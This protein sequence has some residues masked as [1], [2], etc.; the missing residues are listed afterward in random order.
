MPRR[1]VP[2][3]LRI[4]RCRPAL[5]IIFALIGFNSAQ[6]AADLP[7][8]SLDFFE[9]KI[10]PVLSERCYSCH[11]ARSEKLKGGLRLDSRAGV[12]KG[13][14]T[15]PVLTPG[16]PDKSRL[17][18]AIKYEN[19][20]L[21]MPPKGKLSEE[22]I[23]DLSNWVKLGAPWPQETGPALASPKENFDLAQRRQ[24]HWAWQPIRRAP[25]PV[26]RDQAWP[27]SPIDHFIL[28]K[29]EANGL[30][31]AP[32]ADQRT[33]VRRM[34]FDL[35]G[36][37]PTPDEAE[38]FVQ[39]SSSGALD[40]LTGRLLNSPQFGERWARH[41]LDL[42]RYSETLGHEFDY[43]MPNA[44]RYRDYVIRAF[45]S[46]L[47]YD[48]FVMEH[49]AGDLLPNPRRHPTEGF[50]ESVI[51]TGFYWFPQQIHSPVDARQH[52]ADL[53]DN[54]ID[55]LTKT[56]LG[57]TVSCARC[58]DHKFDAIS[59]QDFYALYGILESSRYDQAGIDPPFRIGEKASRLRK[60]KDEIRQQLAGIWAQQTPEIA[61]Y[62]Q[63]ARV[64]MR[65]PGTNSVNSTAASLRL[66]AKHLEQW[67][68][69][70]E[71]KPTNR[72][73]HPTKMWLELNQTQASSRTTQFPERLN[74]L[75]Q[76]QEVVFADFARSDFEKWFVT[77]DAFG[78]RPSPVGD[79]VLG[80]KNEPVVHLIDRAGAHSGQL[81]RR[82]QGVLRSPTFTIDRRYLH[83][84]AAGRDS[85][86]N[87]VVD[88]FLLIRDPIYGGL[89]RPLNHD[90]PRWLTIDVAM[91]K[92]HRAYLECSDLVTGDL[93]H[94]KNG[95][96]G[97][98][99]L[100]RVVFSDRPLPSAESDAPLALSLLGAAPIDSDK[101]L[102]ARY[103]QAVVDAIE[104]WRTNGETDAS[105]TPAQAALLNWM[106]R[107]GLL[108]SESAETNET[109]ATRMK[110]LL[111]EYREIEASLPE[112]TQVPAM[113]A[114]TGLDEQVFI[115]GSHKT[116]GAQVARRFLEAIA[117][118]DQPVIGDAC[119]RLELA[120]RMTDPAN[121][122]LA[123][124]MVNRVWQHLF[125]QGLV[126]SVDNFGALGEPPTHPELLD[127]LADW[128][129]SEAGWSVKKLIRLLVASQTYRMSSAPADAVAEEKDPTDALL[130]RMRLRR[131]EGEAIRDA[132]LFAS[133]RLSQQ[134]FGPS[135]PV[136][137]TPF[138]EG[139]GRP[140]KS[141]PL[142]GDGRRSIYVEVRRNFL[143]PMMLAYDTPIPFTTVGRRTISNVPAQA[144]I[145]MNDPLVAQQA[146][147][148]AQRL[149][150]EKRTDS[151]E[152]I[153]R[154]YQILFCRR[155]NDLEVVQALAF[156]YQQSDAYG[157]AIADR[158][159][160]SRVWSD[161]CHVLF[162]AKEFVFVN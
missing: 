16:D 35:V 160:D 7:S 19:V 3:T 101:A 25:I 50:N 116:P 10:R 5:L 1:P 131:L 135:V 4:F 65:E 153:N 71:Q 159:T 67:V 78:T 93:S 76:R 97:Y 73:A 44:W 119:G 14:E 41:W 28:A 2:I 104:V 100:E 24:S 157:I 133:G 75:M 52:Q 79:F 118:S 64:A 36:L 125:G 49:V 86:I 121:P 99:S 149:L 155:P 23:N 30:K 110:L 63:A 9:K 20:E 132:L 136:Y 94:G 154:L 142:D 113:T 130:H 60:L 88:N 51:G 31:P 161:L 109:A 128:F 89:K 57:L 120:R 150:A 139:R 13:G 54:Q 91:W 26:V 148:L 81:S 18:E 43:A 83:L 140:D 17:I 145:L 127:W 158:L 144:L 146:G 8:D 39:D 137:L 124:V 92:G 152:R 72:T 87:V 105:M 114:G 123:R 147:L 6:A 95:D 53:I 143:S 115:R 55:V 58:H 62:L 111:A 103:Q 11:S 12:L 77:G 32:S 21:Q 33:L 74:T 66:D 69:A 126:P 102:A 37:P 34:H 56:F 27:L 22:Q 47:P 162:N 85:R 38:A 117:G 70:L 107:S 68:Q 108:T 45:N 90:D 59:T 96:N 129:R 141:G 40:K 80:V 138:M 15:G 29:L 84:R 134:M 98:L 112:P 106:L 48:Q 82:L 156:L 151:S 61:A 42:V 46:D 122:F